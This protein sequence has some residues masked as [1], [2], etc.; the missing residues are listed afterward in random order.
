MPTLTDRI[1]T[2]AGSP[3]V[4]GVVGTHDP[5][6]VCGGDCERGGVRHWKSVDVKVTGLSPQPLTPWERLGVW[7][8]IDAI[9]DYRRLRRL[10]EATAPLW[11]QVM[12]DAGSTEADV[13]K[14]MVRGELL[15]YLERRPLGDWP[16]G[17]LRRWEPVKALAESVG[18]DYRARVMDDAG[19]DV[20]LPWHRLRHPHEARIEAGMRSWRA[21]RE[22]AGAGDRAGGAV[23]Q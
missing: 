12:V 16:G 15:P 20:R 22:R 9:R 19:D 6:M 21:A 5:C 8:S 2:S 10:S 17:G 7:R 23:S 1:W 18:I 13:F 11:R 14:R 4:A 3:D